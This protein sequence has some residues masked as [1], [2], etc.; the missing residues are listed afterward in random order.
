MNRNVYWDARGGA[1]IFAGSD[2][3]AWR[4]RG[5]DAD[6]LIADPMFGD[7]AANDFTVAPESP[8]WKLG[9]QKI[10][11]GHLGPRGRPGLPTGS[12]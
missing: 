11:M 6:S 8:V 4:D 7:P 12:R 5:Q 3:A 1:V 2:L 10:D 9:W